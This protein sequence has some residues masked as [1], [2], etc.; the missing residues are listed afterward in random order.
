MKKYK[1]GFTVN[2][3]HPIE[4]EDWIFSPEDSNPNKLVFLGF[5]AN[6]YPMPN[7]S[8]RPDNE[9]NREWFKKLKKTALEFTKDFKGEVWLDD[10]K[11][12][13]NQK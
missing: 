5:D 12:K 1:R 8:K 11:I 6:L 13:E 9:Y 7:L 3:E 4:T 2:G 10:V